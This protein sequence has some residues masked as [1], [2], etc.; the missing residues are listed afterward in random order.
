[1]NETIALLER[2]SGR[3]LEV[4]RTEAVAG[5]QRRTKADTTRIRDDLGWQPST[6]L[7]EGLRAQWAWAAALESPA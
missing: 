2:I 3:T 7:E 1:M 5:D 4:E 6:T